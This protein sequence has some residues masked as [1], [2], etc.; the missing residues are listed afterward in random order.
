VR[1]FWSGSDRQVST[2][3]GSE[4]DDN[5]DSPSRSA[6]SLASSDARIVRKSVS[7]NDRIDRTLFQANQSVSSMHAALKNR[8]RRARKRDQKQEQ[9]EQR[10]RRRSSGSFSLEES[11]DEQAAGVQAVCVHAEKA[12]ENYHASTESTECVEDYCNSSDVISDRVDGSLSIRDV[13][14]AE[15]AN[16]MVFSSQDVL[17]SESSTG[18]GNV[19]QSEKPVDG[20]LLKSK[21]ALNETQ[22]ENI[23]YSDTLQTKNCP[24]DGDSENVNAGICN[25]HDVCDVSLV[26]VFGNDNCESDAGDMDVICDGLGAIGSISQPLVSYEKLGKLNQ[27]TDDNV[28]IAGSESESLKKIAISQMSTVFDLDVD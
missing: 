12:G 4:G 18:N 8:R 13:Y 23:N 3:T 7:F 10:R 19:C 15:I 21:L 1:A 16:E 17:G 25:L 9:R 22:N 26:H 20:T 28:L 11:G 24:A 2:A 14:C 6:T 5:E 27:I